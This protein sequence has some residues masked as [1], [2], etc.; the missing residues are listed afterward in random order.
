MRMSAH[1][2]AR[3]R[4][5]NDVEA[6]CDAGVKARSRPV[7]GSV[8]HPEMRVATGDELGKASRQDEYGWFAPLIT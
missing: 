8:A 5:H 6:K 4:K 7:V 1:R 2:S 3:W